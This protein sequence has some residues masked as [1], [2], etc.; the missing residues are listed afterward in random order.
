VASSRVPKRVLV[1]DDDEGLLDLMKLIL[2]RAG[3]EP[4]LASSGSQGLRLFSEHQPDLAIIDVAMPEM[5]GFQLVEEIARQQ[6]ETEQRIPIIMLSAH[7]Q[8]HLMQRGY[9]LGVDVYLIKPVPSRNM[10]EC[11]DLLL[12]RQSA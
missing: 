11:I 3:F 5:D 7:G 8:E 2:Q 4:I 6:A 9:T 1:V 10:I 12:R